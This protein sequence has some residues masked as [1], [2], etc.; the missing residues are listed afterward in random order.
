MRRVR[1]GSAKTPGKDPRVAPRLVPIITVMGDADRTMLGGAG[2]TAETTFE[3][4]GL[5]FAMQQYLRSRDFTGA[6]IVISV[7]HHRGSDEL[8][9]RRN[10]VCLR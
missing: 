9:R 4:H 6:G 2:G 7:V 3:W 1:A 10:R 8:Y 5:G